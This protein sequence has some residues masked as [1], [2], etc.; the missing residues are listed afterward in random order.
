MQQSDK[1]YSL[2]GLAG[3]ILFACILSACC[4]GH[5]TIPAPDRETV[6]IDDT[7]A[8][9]HIPETVSWVVSLAPSETEIFSALNPETKGISL[10]GRTCYDNY[11][12]AV[13]TVPEVGGPQS[14]SVEA[15]VNKNPDLIL[16]TTVTDK[17]VLD[18]L[19]SLGYPVLIFRLDSFED[20]YHNIE[21]TGE[22]LSLEQ[23]AENLVETL[24]T[25]MDTI[26]QEP[27]ATPSPRVMFVVGTSPIYV[28]GNNTFLDQYITLSG[29]VNVCNK[30]DGYYITSD[31]TIVNQAP[32]IIIVTSGPEN[33]PDALREEL[34]RMDVLKRVPALQNDHICVLD[35]DTVSRPGP[36]I[37]DALELVSACINQ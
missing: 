10:V 12:P 9:V 17:I 14:L 31:E 3:I 8:T 21:L 4:T 22:A 26:S 18:Q 2:I 6:I 25:R 32:D 1:T 24:K 36:R 23:E 11:P 7:D 27:H 33:N 37:V 20:I 19:I 29:G 5:Q 34:T 13:T 15:I 30:T 16:A 35:A 28:A